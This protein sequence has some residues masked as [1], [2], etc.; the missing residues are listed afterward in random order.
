MV[1]FLSRPTQASSS[2]FVLS[3]AMSRYT[4]D[5]ELSQLCG[6][7]LCS[8]LCPE[9]QLFLA[10]NA[11]YDNGFTLWNGCVPQSTSFP[12]LSCCPLR[13]APGAT[14][15][16]V[17]LPYFGI[18]ACSFRPPIMMLSSCV[19]SQ[20]ALFTPLNLAKPYLLPLLFLRLGMKISLTSPHFLKWCHS[21]FSV[22]SSEKCV[23]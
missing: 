13:L 16:G 12:F 18:L 23:K 11:T 6:S 7:V 1:G 2:H 20:W 15:V 10:S 22:M 21:S 8:C 9:R 5:A 17:C 3:G 14:C 4:E 19:A